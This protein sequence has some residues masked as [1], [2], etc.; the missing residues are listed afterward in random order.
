MVPR[1]D[2]ATCV[3]LQIATLSCIGSVKWT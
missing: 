2:E 3:D 1:L